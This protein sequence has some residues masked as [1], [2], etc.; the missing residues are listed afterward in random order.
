[1]GSIGD[2]RMDKENTPQIF[3]DL[4]RCPF[5]NRRPTLKNGYDCDHTVY[6]VWCDNKD[7]LLENV[8]TFDFYNPLD[9]I[10]SWNNRTTK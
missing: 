6:S 7:C 2:T 5:C 1:M 3:F 4:K 10:Q 9:A 8:H